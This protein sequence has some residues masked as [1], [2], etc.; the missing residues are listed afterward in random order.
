MLRILLRNIYIYILFVVFYSVILMSY[1]LAFLS[2]VMLLSLVNIEQFPCLAPFSHAQL[3]TFRYFR[4][5]T[6]KA[7][8]SGLWVAR[9]S[10]NGDFRPV[11]VMAVAPTLQLPPPFTHHRPLS[12]PLLDSWARNIWRSS[13]RV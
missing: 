2:L 8:H 11:H 1:K 9:L 13:R 4:L 6:C 10:T 7:R 3:R 5:N 12:L